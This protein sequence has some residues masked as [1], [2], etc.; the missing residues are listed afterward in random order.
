VIKWWKGNVRLTGKEG[1]LG[2]CEGK[3]QHGKLVLWNGRFILKLILK[4]EYG[5]SVLSSSGS[6]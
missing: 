3:R 5:A 4:K 2:N 1:H 6:I